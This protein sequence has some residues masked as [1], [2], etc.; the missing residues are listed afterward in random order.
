L[1]K[2]FH[3]EETIEKNA[4]EIKTQNK[5]LGGLKEEQRV[6]DKALAE[7]R[8]EQAKARSNVMQKEKKIKK[9]EKA[10]ELKVRSIYTDL[11]DVL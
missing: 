6:H 9:A 4:L 7:V 5:A 11:W 3:I 8:G 10:L 1:Y 2:L